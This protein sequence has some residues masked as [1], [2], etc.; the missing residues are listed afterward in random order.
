[1]ARAG[2]SVAFGTDVAKVWSFGDLG[3]IGYLMAREWGGYVPPETIL[4]MFTR[5]GARA[6]GLPDRLGAL[7]VGRAADIVIRAADLPE[8][9]PGFDPV[10]HLVLIQR[11]K[12]VRTVLCAGRLIVQDG[13]PVTVDLAEVLA[14]AHASARRV[15]E[16]ADLVALPVWQAA[17]G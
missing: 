7:E 1:M 17:K 4:E 8:L 5:G 16:A 6:M 11:T 9:Q 2:V 14:H 10:R 3:T 15:A 13:R 12:G